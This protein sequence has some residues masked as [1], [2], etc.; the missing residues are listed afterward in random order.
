VIQLATRDSKAQ[1]GAIN[2]NGNDA[3]AQI[4][5]INYAR[6]STASI[7]V[8]NIVPRGHTS[9]DALISENGTLL[10][11]VT[12]GGHY[13]RNTY[14]AGARFDKGGTQ[15]VLALGLGARLFTHR[16][17]NLDLD[18]LHEVYVEYESWD[19]LAQTDRLKITTA[20]WVHE[21][22]GVLGSVGY[23]LMY[24][25]RSEIDPGAPFGQSTF[26]GPDARGQGGFYGFP[27]LSLGVRVMLTDPKRPER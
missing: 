15:N 20:V 11:G 27:S 12:H 18:L 4:G 14:A 23:G 13:V 10:A 24:S 17:A 1:I 8:I 6:T 21:R 3:K 26:N 2:L 16:R 22:V 25:D 7:G 19:V 5:V 9:V